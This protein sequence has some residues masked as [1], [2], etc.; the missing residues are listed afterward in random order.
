MAN[1]I[2]NRIYTMVYIVTIFIVYSTFLSQQTNKMEAFNLGVVFG[3]TLMRAPAGVEPTQQVIDMVHLIQ[4]VKLM[5]AEYDQL[6][7]TEW[8]IT[9]TLIRHVRVIVSEEEEDELI[10]IDECFVQ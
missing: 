3:P 2:E 10:Q 8:K 6:F 9:I 1:F 4:V 7:R 5:I